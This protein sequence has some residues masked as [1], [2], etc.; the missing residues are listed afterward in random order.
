MRDSSDRLKL[1]LPISF[2]CKL[3]IGGYKFENLDEEYALACTICPKNKNSKYGP[4]KP[5]EFVCLFEFFDVFRGNFDDT[6]GDLDSKKALAFTNRWGFLSDQDQAQEQVLKLV[7]FEM[8][9]MI[10]RVALKHQKE[11]SNSTK[12]DVLDNKITTFLKD[13]MFA[14]ADRYDGVVTPHIGLADLS[15]AILLTALQRGM[16]DYVQCAAFNLPN[17]KSTCNPGGWVKDFG[18]PGRSTNRFCNDACKARFSR[19]KVKTN[20]QKEEK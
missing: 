16:N 2:H 5:F 1:F 19:W 20:K 15:S 9:R 4:T 18:R 3:S 17:K 13:K 6:Y 8:V 10:I 11:R 12:H 14:T 7:E